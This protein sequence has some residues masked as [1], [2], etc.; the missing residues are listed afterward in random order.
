MDEAP[1]PGGT[2][3]GAHIRQ[4]MMSAAELGIS[5]L[6]ERFPA[7]AD[8]LDP[9]FEWEGVWE[10]F[11]ELSLGRSCGMSPNP[12]SWL[13]IRSYCDLT[14][15]VLTGFELLAIRKLDALWLRVMGES[16]ANLGTAQS[17]H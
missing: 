6:D 3:R 1:A 10:T 15:I 16:Y 14:G 9:P 8:P 17:D 7:P 4:A 13:E 12:I 2:T 5:W 11:R